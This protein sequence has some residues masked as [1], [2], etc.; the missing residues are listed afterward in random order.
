[1]RLPHA[2]REGIDRLP[3]LNAHVARR[4]HQREQLN[5]GPLTI[6]AGALPL[7]SRALHL[8]NRYVGGDLDAAFAKDVV[9]ANTAKQEPAQATLARAMVDHGRRPLRWHGTGNR[10]RTTLGRLREAALAD[11]HLDQNLDRSPSRR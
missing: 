8:M 6:W 10:A 5:C 9:L 3:E 2:D 4:F 11:A 7:A 1:M